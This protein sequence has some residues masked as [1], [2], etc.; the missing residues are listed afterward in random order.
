MKGRIEI[1]RELCK[2]CS[3]CVITCPKK[4]IEME[5]GFNASGYYTARVK[6]IEKCTGCALC[7][8]ICPVVAIEVWREET[9]RE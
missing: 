8:E 5:T 2:G 6:E 3:Y 7:A 9:V 4:I 1:N